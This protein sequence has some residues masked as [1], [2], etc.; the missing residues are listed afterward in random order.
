MRELI[1]NADDLALAA[2]A[3][4]FTATPENDSK[5]KEQRR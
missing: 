5:W 2:S 4:L 1:V 3:A